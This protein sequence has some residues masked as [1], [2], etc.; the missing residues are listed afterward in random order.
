[1]S[2]NLELVIIS[3]VNTQIVLAPHVNGQGRLFGGQ[4]MAWID[5]VGAVEARRFCGTD[6]T[7]ACVD[8][9]SFLK[10]AMLNDTLLLEAQITYTG[11]TSMEVRVDTYVEE[12]TG[13]KELVNTA[14]LVFVSVAGN[15][16]LPVKKFIPKTPL[17]KEEYLSAE[18]RRE[19]R[20][21]HKYNGDVGI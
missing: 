15:E 8:R 5:I 14:Y 9:L 10:P 11:V 21:R 6:V 3:T 18:K 17:E 4:L 1:M 7:T 13:E 19:E 2:P 20:L 16:P 12:L